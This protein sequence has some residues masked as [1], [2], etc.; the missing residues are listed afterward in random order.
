MQSFSWQRSKPFADLALDLIAYAAKDN[1][2]LFFRSSHRGRVLEW[3]AQMLQGKWIDARALILLHTANEDGEL[4]AKPTQK[5]TDILGLLLADIQSDFLHD[6]NGETM[7][8]VGLQSATVD[9]ETVAGL[10]PQDCFSHLAAAG[11]VSTDEKNNGFGF[12]AG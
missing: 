3:P 6:G 8:G 12:S 5:T 4:D 7:H 11:V 2:L 1:Q 10:V 9:F